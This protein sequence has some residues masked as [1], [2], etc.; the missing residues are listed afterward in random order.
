MGYEP[1]V[2]C[3]WCNEPL[4]V[5]APSEERFCSEACE[6]LFKITPDW[7]QVMK[8][9]GGADKRDN[10]LVQVTR[11]TAKLAAS[12]LRTQNAED[13]YHNFMAAERELLGVLED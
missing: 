13:A 12:A 6:R 5:Y 7:N 2:H 1:V 9:C 11:G 8:D 4:D 3:R 10:N